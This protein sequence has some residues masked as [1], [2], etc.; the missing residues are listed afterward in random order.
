MLADDRRLDRHRRRDFASAVQRGD[1]SQGRSVRHRIRRGGRAGE[2]ADAEPMRER[3]GPWRVGV[4]LGLVLASKYTVLLACPIFL[5]LVDSPF[6]AR[7]TLRQWTIA[8]ALV[9]LLALPWYV[10]NILLTGNPLYPV[11]VHLPGLKLA[12][13]FTTER[14]QQLRTA[15]GVW[16]ML[17]DNYHSLPTPLIVLLLGGWAAACILGGRRTKSCASRSSRKVRDRLDRDSR[18]LS[19]HIAAS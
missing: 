15:G 16:H 2:A 3:P 12:G 17:S 5:F 7:W 18:P 19:H 1:F 6:R 4:S 13:L 11:D 8:I 14:D 9:A 10:R